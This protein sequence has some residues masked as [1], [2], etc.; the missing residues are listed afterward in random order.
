MDSIQRHGNP[1]YQQLFSRELGPPGAWR[2]K[3]WRERELTSF[4]ENF[5]IKEKIKKRVVAR[6]TF[7]I[8]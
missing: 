7:V 8:K 6:L 2:R 4:S 5:V 1:C 3:H